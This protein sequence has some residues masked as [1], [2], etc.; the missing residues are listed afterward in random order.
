MNARRCWYGLLWLVMMGVAPV[1]GAE[2]FQLELSVSQNDS[3]VC[4][5]RLVVTSGQPATVQIGDVRLDVVATR[6]AEGIT[7]Q[8]SITN[9][10]GGVP[11]KISAPRIVSPLGKQWTV[12]LADAASKMELKGI[13][14]PV[15]VN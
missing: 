12:E 10:V 14:L 9:I 4:A 1:V 2:Q 6:A 11:R 7:Q 3:L 8:V 15:P 5:P 13:V